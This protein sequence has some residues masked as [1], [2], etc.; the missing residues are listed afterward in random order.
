M[1]L[2]SATIARSHASV[3]LE[4][5]EIEL[6]NIRERQAAGIAVAEKKGIYQGRRSGTT[7]G[8]PARAYEPTSQGPKLKE[9]AAESSITVKPNHRL[10]PS[11]LQ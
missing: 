4:L 6:S 9:I 8:K 3:L 11:S 5:G 2:M 7:K 1:P 10:H